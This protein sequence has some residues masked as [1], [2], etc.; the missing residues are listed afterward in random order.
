MVTSLIGELVPILGI[1]AVFG[2]PAAVIIVFAILRHRQRMELIRQGI[3]PDTGIPPYPGQR[4][5]LFGMLLSLIGL[6]IIINGILNGD[7]NFLRSGLPITG[8]GIA[9]LLYWKLTAPDRERIKRL[10][11][12]RYAAGA[13]ETRTP[14]RRAYAEPLVSVKETETPGGAE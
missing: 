13:A 12:E 2:V 14:V 8:A 10:F 9:I 4:A 11:E 5:L 3:N 1:I 6:A 7:S